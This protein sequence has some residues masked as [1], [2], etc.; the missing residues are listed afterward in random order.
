MQKSRINVTILGSEVRHEAK[1]S[2]TVYKMLVQNE[3]VAGS[4]IEVW[5]RYRY[6][7]LRELPCPPTDILRTRRLCLFFV[8]HHI[9][10]SSIS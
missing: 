1:K 6:D 3:Q 8:G 2:F 7:C 9:S 5:R 4:E 10:V